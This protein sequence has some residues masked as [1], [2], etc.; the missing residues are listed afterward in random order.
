MALEEYLITYDY[1][2][3]KLERLDMRIEELA[4]TEQYQKKVKRLCCL[5]GVK[6]H[7]ALSVLVEIG[8]FARFAKADKLAGYLGLVSGEDSSG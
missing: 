7:I 5:I 3:N 2:K 6:T 4:G 8:D 1:H